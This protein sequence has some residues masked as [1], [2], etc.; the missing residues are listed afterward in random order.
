MTIAKIICLQRPPFKTLLAVNDQLFF[1]VFA[2][3]RETLDVKHFT[4]VTTI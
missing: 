3:L 4:P 2:A 1:C